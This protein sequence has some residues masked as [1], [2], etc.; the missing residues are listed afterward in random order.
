[1]DAKRRS[2]KDLRP[3]LINISN[4]EELGKVEISKDRIRLGA[5]VTMTDILNHAELGKIAPALREAADK[6]ASPQIRNVATIGGNFANASPA[7]DF[8]IP[9]ICLDAEIELA[10]W[11][12]DMV[13]SRSVPIADF[14]PAPGNP[15]ARLTN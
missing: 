2:A 9:L 10:R 12:D 3:R 5:R 8:V 6:F 11:Q 14:L 7:A 13:A 1:M 4:I 15:F